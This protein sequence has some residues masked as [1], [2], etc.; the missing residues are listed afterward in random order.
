MDACLYAIIQYLKHHNNYYLDDLPQCQLNYIFCGRYHMN[1][2]NILMHRYGDAS[3][4]VV[5]STLQRSVLK[6][7]HGQ[8][9][10]GG[11]KVLLRFTQQARYWW[12]GLRKDI[13]SHLETCDGCQRL[14]KGRNYAANSGHI[15]TSSK[16]TP[17]ELVSIDG[18]G[19]L[20]QTSNDNRYIVSLMDKFSRFCML[21]PI[22]DVKT[23]TV[24]RA[25][26]KWINLFGVPK[27]LLSDNGTQFTSEI[28]RTFTHTNNNHTTFLNTI[29]PRM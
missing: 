29:L 7:A 28:F 9:H 14:Q 8:V 11:A 19:P 26:Q 15:K 2:Q 6:W 20:P 3:A 27:N 21:V 24:V 4:I 17:F 13:Q 22:K 23:L 12:I 25:Y 16:T 10:H 18:C 5:S 1:H